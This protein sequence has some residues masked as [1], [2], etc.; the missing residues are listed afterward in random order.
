MNFFLLHLIS[1][2]IGNCGA[3]PISIAFSSPLTE[4]IW[5]HTQFDEIQTIAYNHSDKPHYPLTNNV[6][7]NQKKTN[8]QPAPPE[9]LPQKTNHN[10]H[11]PQHQPPQP[12]HPTFGTIQNHN[13]HPLR[14]TRPLSHQRPHLRDQ[15]PAF[16]PLAHVVLPGGAWGC[17]WVFEC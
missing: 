1:S 6:N 2:Q 9:H 11:P 17:D 7:R 12:R 14:V 5:N 8:R 4:K 3:S 13:R 16:R 10:H 15:D